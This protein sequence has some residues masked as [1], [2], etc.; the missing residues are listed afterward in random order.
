[1]DSPTYAIRDSLALKL[2]LG[3]KGL[4]NIFNI[5]PSDSEHQSESSSDGTPETSSKGRSGVRAP[6]FNPSTNTVEP[7][8]K[9]TYYYEYLGFSPEKRGS[10]D[11][12]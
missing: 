3:G 6:E 5:L 8:R 2:C 12:G 9:A 10:G 4:S 7:N 1:M 11:I